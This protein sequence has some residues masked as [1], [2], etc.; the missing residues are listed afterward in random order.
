MGGGEEGGGALLIRQGEQED[1][2][3][4]GLQDGGSAARGEH[5]PPS[6]LF[7]LI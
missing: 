6:F 1:E 7:S 2:A 4:L 3:E 5:D